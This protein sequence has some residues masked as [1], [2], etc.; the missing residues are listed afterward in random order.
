M[1]KSETIGALAAALAIV[2]S[3]MLPTVKDASNP[4]FK[5]K[6]ADL[7]A[8]WDA[9]RTLLAE[10]QLSVSQLPGG[11]G[12]TV[13]LTTVLMHASGEWLACEARAAP[14]DQGPQAVGSAITYLRR[15]ALAAMVGIV[16]EE[17]DDGN[18]AES[19]AKPAAKFGK[20]DLAARASQAV[21]AQAVTTPDAMRNEIRALAK[22]KGRSDVTLYASIVKRFDVGT[23]ENVDAAIRALGDDEVSQLID[24]LNT[25]PNV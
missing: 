24:L 16:A 4:F 17:D 6:Y 12:Q 3:K 8:V 20:A 1:S 25:L 11:D 10:Q 23:A 5:S 22:R 18:A 2:Q 14:K 19:H 9:C 7:G 15:Y 21:K 13:T